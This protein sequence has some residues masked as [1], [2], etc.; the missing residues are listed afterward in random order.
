MDAM[1]IT[2]TRVFM[3]LVMIVLLGSVARADDPPI[4]KP[5][6]TKALERLSLGN[7]LYNVRS[8]EEA[9]TE[10]K[11]GALIESAPIFDFNLGQC[12]RQ[13]GKYQDAIWHYQRFVRTSPETPF[14][15][16]VVHQF[17]DQ[18][19][20]ELEKKAMTQ[21]P[22]EAATDTASEPSA[23]VSQGTVTS[24]TALTTEPPPRW[25]ED[26]LGWGLASAGVVGLGVA[27]GFLISASSL[28]DD[29]NHETDQRRRSELHDRGDTRALLGAVIGIGGAA[30]FVVGVV[31]LAIAPDR[32][33][34]ASNAVGLSIAPNGVAVFGRV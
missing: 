26:G 15:I 7:K 6:A 5:N 11:A 9:T 14:R 13:L 29:A 30:V 20:G 34:A 33:Q 3:S 8:F 25:Y 16:T 28:R 12:Y 24:S 10:Y 32:R 22:T 1:E 21:P 2:L 4:R 31:K 18:M 17:I 27:A 23:S 19:K